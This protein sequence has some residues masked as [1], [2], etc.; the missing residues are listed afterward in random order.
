M[1]W[2]ERYLLFNFKPVFFS[3]TPGIELAARSFNKMLRNVDISSNSGLI[4]DLDLSKQKA[5]ARH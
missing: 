5:H 3:I 4:F 2:G 1:R